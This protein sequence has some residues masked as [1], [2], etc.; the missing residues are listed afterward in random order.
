MFIRDLAQPAG[1][2]ANT[3][4]FYET[5]GFLDMR[6]SVRGAYHF[7]FVRAGLRQRPDERDQQDGNDIDEHSQ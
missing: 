5:K 2:S 1:I 3:I 4:R 6:V 7:R